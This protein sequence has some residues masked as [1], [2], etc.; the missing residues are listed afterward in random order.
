MADTNPITLPMVRVVKRSGALT[1]AQKWLWLDLYPFYREGCWLTASEQGLAIGLAEKSVDEYRRLLLKVG[2]ARQGVIARDGRRGRPR[3]TWYAA[4]PDHLEPSSRKLAES[5][6]ARLADLLDLHIEHTLG[7][8]SPSIAPIT[9]GVKIEPE[10]PI[11]P[12]G[13]GVKEA[14]PAG[15]ASSRGEGGGGMGLSF[16]VQG[17]CPSPSTT[18]KGRETPSESKEGEGARANRD[19]L[20]PTAPLPEHE[21]SRIHP[22]NRPVEKTP[23]ADLAERL[24]G[25]EQRLRQG[26]A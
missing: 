13:D 19:S 7:P 3:P 5:E 26:A 10:P 4:F 17:E 11:N 1:I 20:E 2:L 18:Y 23:P 24:A 8:K 25:W 22:H 21:F 9:M 16:A 6:V 14:D 12:Y 15:G